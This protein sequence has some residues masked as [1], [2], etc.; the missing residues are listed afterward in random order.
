ML[1]AVLGQFAEEG[2]LIGQRLQPSVLLR[3]GFA[4]ADPDVDSALASA[5]SP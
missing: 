1:K 4:F 3:S 2:V 5:L